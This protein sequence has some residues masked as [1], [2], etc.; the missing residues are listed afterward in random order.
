MDADSLAPIRVHPCSS[1]VDSFG[2]PPCCAESIRGFHLCCSGLM[3]NPF[4]DL[5]LTLP[6][7]VFRDLKVRLAL[8]LIFGASAALVVWSIVYRLPDSDRKLERQQSK[9]AELENQ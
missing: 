6:P 5:V 2:L 9:I 3:Q 4:K 7:E 1:V 8:L